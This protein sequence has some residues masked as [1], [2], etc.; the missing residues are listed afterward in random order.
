MITK[1]MDMGMIMKEIK[2]KLDEDVGK[3][4]IRI[5]DSK[6]EKLFDFYKQMRK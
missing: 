4:D 3:R 2:R 1:E 5:I 6:I